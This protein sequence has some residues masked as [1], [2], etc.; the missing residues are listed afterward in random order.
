MLLLIM[1]LYSQYINKSHVILH[2]LSLVYNI[3]GSCILKCLL[4]PKIN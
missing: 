2:P 4:G 3:E 1:G